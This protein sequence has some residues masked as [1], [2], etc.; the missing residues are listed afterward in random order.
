[1]R[2]RCSLVREPAV[3]GR[4]QTAG[5]GRLREWQAAVTRWPPSVRAALWD[6][7]VVGVVRKRRAGP[8]CH[9][10]EEPVATYITKG[11]SQERV[12][13]DRLHSGV[14]EAAGGEV[15]DVVA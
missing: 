9:V 14:I 6:R 3:A 8:S 5:C 7:E 2:R 12:V 4:G 1:M 11:A 10:P 15:A 13:H